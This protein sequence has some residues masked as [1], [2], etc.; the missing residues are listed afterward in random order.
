MPD[1]ISSNE[2]IQFEY[3]FV[4]GDTRISNV[5]NPKENISAADIIELN[6]FLRVNNALV[7]DRYNST[8]AQINYA[9][10]V[11]KTTTTF[12]INP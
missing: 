3:A 1:T 12:D 7:G 2:T 4:D 8:F 11:N 5:K 6:Q 10:R 9:K